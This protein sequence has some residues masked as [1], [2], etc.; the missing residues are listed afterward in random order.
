MG[1]PDAY[2]YHASAQAFHPERLTESANRALHGRVVVDDGMPCDGASVAVFASVAGDGLQAAKAWRKEAMV[3]TA[4]DGRYVVE[5][6][7]YGLK[8][9][10]VTKPGF[11]AAVHD[12]LIVADGYGGGMVGTVLHRGDDESFSVV[13]S[14]GEAY[15]GGPATVATSLGHYRPDPKP[16][17]AQGVLRVPSHER[18]SDGEFVLVVGEPPILL[19]KPESSGDP[20]VIPA[21]RDIRINARGANAGDQVVLVFY[22]HGLRS[23]P[24][25]CVRWVGTGCVIDLEAVPEWPYD[26]HVIAESREG[27]ITLAGD[28]A[29][30][31]LF[32]SAREQAARAWTGSDRAGREGSEHWQLSSPL[33]I[34]SLL[35]DRLD[36]LDYHGGTEPLPGVASW[37]AQRGWSVWSGKGALA[38]SREMGD[39][40][41]HAPR[42]G[43]SL[44]TRS[45]ELPLPF[46]LARF[47]SPHGVTQSLADRFGEVTIDVPEGPLVIMARSREGR[48]N[49]PQGEWVVGGG[50]SA[51]VV[52]RIRDTRGNWV[53]GF[54]LDA[55]ERALP[56][57][58]VELSSEEEGRRALTDEEGFYYFSGLAAG[59]YRVSVLAA[60]GSAGPS[61]AVKVPASRAGTVLELDR[62]GGA[63]FLKAVD[64]GSADVGNH[65]S[66]EP[67]EE[68][69][70]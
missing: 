41:V 50:G 45:F 59:D 63:A 26:L 18:S 13:R 4:S 48:W 12:G 32:L 2:D 68:P 5:E 46:L 20:L 40:S 44:H 17:I 11:F 6:L 29:E 25:A 53:A 22:P 35:G 43:G 49:G 54:V 28:R 57:L 64:Y 3:R 27:W 33:E 56:D 1:S 47:V 70:Q 51:Q 37:S 38:H 65:R 55:H 16:T 61:Q 7:S 30:Y 36:W 14:N 62:M 58:V 66:A 24:W 9:L 31:E 39:A 42:G 52:S 34:P 10:V 60:D 21:V 15:E 23:L 8:V 19:S 67:H 69:L